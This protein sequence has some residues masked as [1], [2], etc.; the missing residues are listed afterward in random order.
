MATNPMS[1]GGDRRRQRGPAGADP[2]IQKVKAEELVPK[3]VRIP[4]S[5]NRRLTLAQQD[6]AQQESPG[7]MLQG[8]RTPV[9][10]H[11][12]ATW[13][14][15]GDEAKPACQQSGNI[16]SQRGTVSETRFF[17]RPPWSAHNG[18]WGALVHSCALM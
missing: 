16:A 10:M 17:R 2:V 9:R 3:T 6:V 12:P 8:G 5:L 15:R 7:V 18:Q 4:R 11:E 14:K 13:T 1:L